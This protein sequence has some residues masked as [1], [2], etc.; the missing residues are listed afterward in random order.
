[1]AFCNE[2]VE[3]M[4]I[5]AADLL[6]LDAVVPVFRLKGCLLSLFDAILRENFGTC[7]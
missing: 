3:D 7:T 4:A 2:E 1:V 5:D 6:F